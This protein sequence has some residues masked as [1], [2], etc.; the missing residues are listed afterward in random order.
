MR[1]GRWKR[2]AIKMIVPA[3]LACLLYLPAQ[4][5]DQMIDPAYP[6]PQYVHWLLD[7]ARGELGYQEGSR[8]YTKYGEW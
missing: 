3:L 2:A 4:A 5:E 1:E 8:G 7:V 6:V